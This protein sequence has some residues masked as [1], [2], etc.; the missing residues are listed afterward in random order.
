MW[1]SPDCHIGPDVTP[2]QKLAN[3]M[4]LERINKT[5]YSLKLSGKY[6]YNSM[7]KVVNQFACYLRK[8]S[9]IVP[10]RQEL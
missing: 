5:N 8:Q 1:S 10:Y 2:M 9:L 4:H 3:T 7:Y 6:T